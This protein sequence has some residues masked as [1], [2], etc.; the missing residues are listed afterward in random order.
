MACIIGHPAT[1]PKQIEAG[2]VTGFNG[3]QIRYNDTDTLPGNSGS[4]ILHGPTGR[5][6]GVH[7]NGGCAGTTPETGF[8]LGMRISAS[9]AASPIIQGLVDQRAG[10]FAAIWEQVGGPPF[11]ARHNL[12]AAEYQQTFDQLVGQQG[13]RL[14][15]VSGYTVGGQERFAAIWQQDGGPPFTARHNLTAG[16]YQETFDQLVGQGLRLRVVDGFQRI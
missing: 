16:E 2:P 12:T 7:T 9:I 15:C 8:N 13:F 5:L 14:T 6:I 1:A 3:N 11:T 10:I 4:G